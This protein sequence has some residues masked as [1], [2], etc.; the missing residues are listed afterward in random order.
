[1]VAVAGEA[2]QVEQGVVVLVVQTQE[3][4]ELRAQQI[5]A[6]AV[7][8]ILKMQTLPQLTLVAMVVLA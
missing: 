6:A 4:Q 8:A 5:L 7:V 3:R 1:V 2:E